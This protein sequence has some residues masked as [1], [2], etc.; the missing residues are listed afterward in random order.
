MANTEDVRTK[1]LPELL[2][3]Y[4]VVIEFMAG[5]EI[6]D[7]NYDAVIDQKEILKGAPEARTGTFWLIQM[8]VM[9]IE[10]T[11]EPE[12]GPAL[13]LPWGS[14]LKIYSGDSR[15]KIEERYREGMASSDAAAEDNPT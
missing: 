12:G 11:R 9:G 4:E 6:N 2:L 7:E 15:E 10:V 5:P 3:G 14:V 13:F 1:T 8:S